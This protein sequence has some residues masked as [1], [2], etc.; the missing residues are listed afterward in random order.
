MKEYDNSEKTARLM[1]DDY[2]KSVTNELGDSIEGI[3][4]LGSLVYGG[5]IPGPGDIDQITILKN[6]AAEEIEQQ[7]LALI[8]STMGKYNNAVNIATTIYRKSQLERP[9]QTE[10]DCTPE[11]KHLVTV[12]EEL[13]R[14]HDHGQV[15][16]GNIDVSSLPKPTIDE[17]KEYHLRWRKWN[18]IFFAQSPEHKKMIESPPLRIAVAS[19]ISMAIWHYYYATG[20]TCFNKHKISGLLKSAVHNYRYLDILETATNVR[21]AAFQNIADNIQKQIINGFF[22]MYGWYVQHD[23]GE[24]PITK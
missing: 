1:L 23:I 16:W 4:L 7:V 22:A 19:I 14:I 20:K 2:V 15:I 18:E 21:R 24:I 13:L 3:I 9:W 6:D 10:Y 11:S 8:K 17:M 12:P 5:Y